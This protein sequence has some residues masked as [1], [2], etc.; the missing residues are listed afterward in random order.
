MMSCRRNLIYKCFVLAGG[1]KNNITFRDRRLHI[2][3]VYLMRACCV[4]LPLPFLC[5][6]IHFWTVVLSEDVKNQLERQSTKYRGS[7]KSWRKR[8][9]IL[10]VVQQKLAY[11][12]HVLR[13]SSGRNAL[14]I[15][16][17]KIRGKRAKGRPKRTEC[18]LMMSGNGQY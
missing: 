14:V 18:G 6:L 12:G 2:T 9:A 15:L 13:G 10:S 8:T 16:E 11:A 3:A 7:E 4:I 1:K 17:G 5:F